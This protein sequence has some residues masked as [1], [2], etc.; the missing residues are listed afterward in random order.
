[1]MQVVGEMYEMST[2][3]EIPEYLFDSFFF[4]FFIYFKFSSGLPLFFLIKYIKQWKDL[5]TITIE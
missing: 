1:M 3:M 2:L 5:E 4:C